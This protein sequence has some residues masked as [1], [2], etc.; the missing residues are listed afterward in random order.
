M[1]GLIL[2]IKI[3]IA[4]LDEE[5]WYIMYKYD[6]EFKKYT[7]QSNLCAQLFTKKIILN[8]RIEYRLLGKLHCLDHPA[9]IENMGIFS[10][11]V[12]YKAGL[13]HRDDDDPAVI[14]ATGPKYWYKHC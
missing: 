1:L 2:D 7:Q 6:D 3:N 13:K 11:Q 4:S 10:I 12:W 14:L 8:N 9:V 5:V